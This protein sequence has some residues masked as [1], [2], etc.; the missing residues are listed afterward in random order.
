M[1]KKIEV[2]ING[3]KLRIPEHMLSDFMKF[4]AMQTKREVKNPPKELLSTIQPKRVITPPKE[5][6]EESKELTE[7][8]EPKPITTPDPLVPKA[9][10]T[11][12]K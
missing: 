7:F 2:E 10:K 3:K 12:K 4:G 11:R 9:K 6:T 8:P 1:D 5:L